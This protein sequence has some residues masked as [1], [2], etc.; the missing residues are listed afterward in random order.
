MLKLLTGLFAAYM[1]GSIP[2]AFI[3]GKILKGIDIRKVGSGNTGATNVYRSIGKTPGLIV[4]F[5]DVLKGAL[6]VF[7]IPGL[8]NGMFEPIGADLYKILIGVAAISG[9]VW[10]IFLNFKG[11]KGVATT[12]GVGIVMAPKVISVAFIVWIIIFVIWRYV[13]LASIIAAISLPILAILFKMHISYIALFL[14]LGLMGIYKHKS[15]I[16]RLINRTES[17]IF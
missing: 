11:G 14:M 7:L 15:N 17:K 10:T 13:S 8:M 9:H 5:L 2:T 1:I 3:F 4:L 6:P 16:T 12:A